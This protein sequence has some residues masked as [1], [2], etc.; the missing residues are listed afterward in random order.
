[1][2]LG[3]PVSAPEPAIPTAVGGGLGSGAGGAGGAGSAG[4]ADSPGSASFFSTGTHSD[5]LLRGWVP[6]DTGNWRRSSALWMVRST[7]VLVG[8]CRAF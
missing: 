4:S 3:P 7:G 5:S 8:S 1:M 2:A 6:D